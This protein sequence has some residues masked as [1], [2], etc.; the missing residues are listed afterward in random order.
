MLCIADYLTICC[1]PTYK[2]TEDLVAGAQLPPDSY[3]LVRYE[4]LV[5][6]PVATLRS[7]Y[8]VQLN[9]DIVTLDTSRYLQFYNCDTDC[10]SSWV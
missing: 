5:A 4:D 9:I 2:Y 10:F 3:Q 6:E 8:E 7:L 1:T